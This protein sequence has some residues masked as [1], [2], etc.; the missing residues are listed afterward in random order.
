M[1]YDKDCFR[2]TPDVFPPD[3]KS[4]KGHIYKEEITIECLKAFSDDKA[5]RVLTDDD[6][7]EEVGCLYVMPNDASHRY[8]LKTRLVKVYLLPKNDK[9]AL[10]E[11]DAQKIKPLL[12]GGALSHCF[13]RPVVESEVR[14]L[15]LTHRSNE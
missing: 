3:K 14:E 12:T 15:D 8:K 13:V 1:E 4:T 6:R 7:D 10:R 11:I 2:I 9:E 5:I